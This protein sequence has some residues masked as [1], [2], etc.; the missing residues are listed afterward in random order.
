MGLFAKTP[1]IRR[2]IGTGGAQ[3]CQLPRAG[4]NG[5]GVE[6]R[7]RH[8]GRRHPLPEMRWQQPD[9]GEVEERRQ[10]LFQ[11]EANRQACRAI[12]R[13]NLDRLPERAQPRHPR[14]VVGLHGLHRVEHIGRGNRRAVVPKEARAQ[15]E[16]VREAIGAGGPALS[17]VRNDVSLLIQLGQSAEKQGNEQPVDLVI[18]AQ[19]GIEELWAACH[20]LDVDPA[21]IRD[22]NRREVEGSIAQ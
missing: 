16:V 2:Q 4:A 19:E 7:V 3:S 1:G 21:A 17:Q 15:A 22:G 11:L 6:L 10:R 18:L 20:P 8:L 14:E 12:G 5:P 13:L 9:G